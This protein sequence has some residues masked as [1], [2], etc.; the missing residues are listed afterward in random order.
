MEIMEPAFKKKSIKWRSCYNDLPL[1]FNVTHYPDSIMDWFG[2]QSNIGQK[3]MAVGIWKAGSGHFQRHIW[4]LA[5][6]LYDVMFSVDKN[7]TRAGIKV[8]VTSCT[9]PPKLLLI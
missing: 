7:G 8:N 9:I 5:A 1:S 3:E 2:N 4:K 6:A